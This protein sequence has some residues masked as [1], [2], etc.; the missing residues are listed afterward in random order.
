MGG[1]KQASPIEAIFLSIAKLKHI[2]SNIYALL[3]KLNV[4][5]QG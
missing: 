1:L 5:R 2:K 3:E 4:K